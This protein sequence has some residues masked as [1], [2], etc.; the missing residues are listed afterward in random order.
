[1]V[2]LM[3]AGKRKICAHGAHIRQRSQGIVLMRTA[4]Q[5]KKQ[6]CDQTFSEHGQSE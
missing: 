1:M 6:R 4:E 2:S 5:A 3:R